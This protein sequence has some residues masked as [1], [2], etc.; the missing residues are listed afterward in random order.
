MSDRKWLLPLCLAFVSLGIALGAFGPALF[1]TSESSPQ[2]ESRAVGPA[3]VPVSPVP[4]AK[5]SESPAPPDD[6]PPRMVD[7]T[8]ESG[9]DFQHFNG[10]TGRYEYLEVMGGGVV[11]FDFD[12]DDDLDLYFVSGNRVDGDPDPTITNRLFRNEGG[13]KFRD[14]TAAAGVGDTGYGQGAAA[15]DYDQDGDLDLVRHELRSQCALS[16][17]R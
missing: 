6:S 2:A 5:P 14:V 15:A 3:D 8:E 17:Q 10:Q 1:S 16:Q 9:I 7:I 11:C 4:P 12:Q 13:M